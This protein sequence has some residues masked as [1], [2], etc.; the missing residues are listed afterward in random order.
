[1]EN[2]YKPLIT[3][4]LVNHNYGRYI[5]KAIE[6]VVNQTMGDYEL[7]IIDDGSTDNSRE[8][9]AHYASCHDNIITIFQHNK[10]L[11]VT[12]NI[13]LRKAHGKYIMRLDADDWLDEH[14]LQILSGVLEKHSDVGMVFPDYYYVDSDG[15]LLETIRRHDF[16]DVS[17]MD[18]PAH[19]AC[20]M[21]R[22]HCLREIGG[23]DEEFRRQDGYE[24][25]IRFVQHY[26]VKNVNLPLFYYRQHPVS[27]TKSEDKLL[28][29]RSNILAKRARNAQSDVNN[30]IALIPIRGS[31]TEPDSQVLKLLGGKPLINWTIDAALEAKRIKDIIVSTPDD[32]VLSHVKSTYGN[33]VM[34]IRRKEHMA[35]INSFLQQT[36]DNA[37]EEYI[38]QNKDTPLAISLLFVE[39]PF[40]GPRYIDSSIDVLELFGTDTVVGVRAETDT[41]YKHNGQGLQLVKRGEN[42]RLESE[43]IYRK[44]GGIH[45]ISVESFNKCKKY[46]SGKTGHIIIDEMAGLSLVSEWHWKLAELL[47]GTENKNLMRETRP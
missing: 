13:A 17:L 29:T 16:E 30:S 25:W 38:A 19:G 9:I 18:Q 31:V 42:L 12:N 35:Q 26:E 32:K 36:I 34:T 8:I 44:S 10:G 37:L 6:S 41:F 28:A 46:M 40:R 27:L 14:A 3:V 33:Q 45:T 23:Y 47:C 39:S 21:I 2:N 22:T 15:V 20:T 4:Y 7:I 24:L 1:M 11:N 43:E 5:A